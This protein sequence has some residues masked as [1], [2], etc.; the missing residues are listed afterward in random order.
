MEETAPQEPS[1]FAGGRRTIATIVYIICSSM[2]SFIVKADKLH[3]CEIMWERMIGD[4]KAGSEH[5]NCLRP[6]ISK[7]K[8]YVSN[9]GYYDFSLFRWTE[10]RLRFYRANHAWLSQAFAWHGDR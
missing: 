6:W 7:S 5:K 9:A 3:I 10:V 8:A 4:S 1:R 2:L